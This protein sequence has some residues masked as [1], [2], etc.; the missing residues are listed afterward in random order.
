MSG[1]REVLVH[2][3]VA[4]PAGDERDADQIRDA[5]MGALEV[6]SD[7]D[8]LRGLEIVCPMAEEV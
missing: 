6:G 7:A 1:A 2:L 3:N 5:V 8:E 4:V